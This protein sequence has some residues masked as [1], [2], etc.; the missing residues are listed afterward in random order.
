[1]SFAKISF[2]SL[3]AIA[4]LSTASAA[5]EAPEANAEPEGRTRVVAA[6]STDRSAAIAD[7]GEDAAARAPAAAQCE[8]P[9]AEGTSN[10]AV[11]EGRP[12][13]P[14]AEGVWSAAP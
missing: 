9:Q 10:T 14:G 13:S 1:M 3:A 6:A 8:T 2:A 4:L 5:S 12:S 11:I 7:S